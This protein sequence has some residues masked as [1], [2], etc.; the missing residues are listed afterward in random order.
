MIRPFAEMLLELAEALL[1]EAGGI[2]AVR[3][4]QL[5]LPMEIRFRKSD[6]QIELLADVPR[7]RW[8]TEFDTQP[9]R[10]EIELH[11]EVAL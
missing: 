6:K 7:W 4:A 11:R 10:L 8:R 5:D 9:G 2:V 3:S 1:P